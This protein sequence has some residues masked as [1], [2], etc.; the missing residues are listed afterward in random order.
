MVPAGPSFPKERAPR[1]F[2][3]GF[4][5]VTDP[6]Q[7]DHSV[8]EGEATICRALPG[9]LTWRALRQTEL[10]ET[11]SLR[12]TRRGADEKVVEFDAHAG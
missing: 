10:N 8:G 5:F 12:S 11:V 6:E 2:T 3:L 1:E 9:M 4:P 7:F